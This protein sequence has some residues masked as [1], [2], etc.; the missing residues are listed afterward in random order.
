MYRFSKIFGGVKRS[1]PSIF[2]PM[3]LHLMVNV[4]VC[5]VVCVL[6]ETIF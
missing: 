1:P 6:I 3:G 5:E 4:N 2:A